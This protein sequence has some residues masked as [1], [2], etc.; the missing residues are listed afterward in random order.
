MHNL[1][2]KP[3]NSISFDICSFILA[4]VKQQLCRKVAPARQAPNEAH[5][6]GEES[7]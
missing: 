5:R 4:T 1:F 6:P 7:N 2:I 3:T